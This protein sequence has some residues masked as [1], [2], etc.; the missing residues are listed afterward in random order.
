MTTPPTHLQAT[1]HIA[2]SPDANHFLSGSPDSTLLL[3]SLPSLLSFQYVSSYSDTPSQFAP[4]KTLSTH[5]AAITALIF[6]HSHGKSSI[7]ISASIDKTLLVW[8]PLRG[9]TLHTFLLSS[10]ALCLAL[11]PADRACY[12][13]YEDGSIQYIDFYKSSG[14]TQMLRDAEMQ[15]TPTQPSYEERWRLPSSDEGQEML[16]LQTSYDGMTLLSGHRNGK[17]QNWDVGRGRYSSMLVEYD[18]PVTNVTML[19]PTGFPNPKTRHLK[20]KQV[21][22]PKYESSF[23]ADGA[24]NAGVVPADYTFT[25]QFLS[26]LPLS[27]R[28]ER[29]ERDFQDALYHPSFPAEWLEEGIAAFA[30]GSSDQNVTK[31]DLDQVD[32]GADESSLDVNHSQQETK[33]LQTENEILKAQLAEAMARHR[34]TINENI[35]L[36]KQRW[37]QKDEERIKGEKKKRR[38]LR[39]IAAAERARKK[40][41]GETVEE[42]SDEEMGEDEEEEEDL[43]SSTDEITDSD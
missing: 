19:P 3:W 15:G 12:A 39:R 8:D 28:H 7:A 5:R 31:Q 30:T 37:R 4:R 34:V 35:I 1:T 9:E 40:V 17:I 27:T 43:S 11:D 13:G 36:E 20:L 23:A 16:C 6:G 32:G 21:V 22:K 26:N 42:E 24:G 14:V 41:M 38:R 33:N 18:H 25:A 2:I 10:P 29:A